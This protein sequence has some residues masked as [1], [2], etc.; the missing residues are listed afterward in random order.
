MPAY[1]TGFKDNIVRI[2]MSPNGQSV[3]QICK[4]VGLSR[5]TLYA[6]KQQY[7]SKDNLVLVNPLTTDLWDTKSKLAAIIQTALMNESRTV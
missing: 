2:I 4:E 7:R 6:W 1:S 3:E 5:S